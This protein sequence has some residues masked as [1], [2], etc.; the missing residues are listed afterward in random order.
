MK[1]Y[2]IV[3][4]VIFLISS[5]VSGQDNFHIDYDYSRLCLDEKSGYIEIYYSF[6]PLEM[7]K[8][9]VEEDTCVT[10]VI[11]IKIGKKRVRDLFVDRT[12][13]L[14]SKVG[15]QKGSHGSDLVGLFRFELPE[16]EYYCDITGYDGNDS[17]KQFIDSFNFE[18]KELKSD[19]FTVSDLQLA[20]SIKKVT[21]SDESPFYK[22]QYEVIPNPSLMFGSE[23][24]VVFLYCELYGINLSPESPTL[25]IEYRLVDSRNQELLKKTKFIPSSIPSMVFVKPINVHNYQ[26]GRHQMTLTVSDTIKKISE[27]VSK[28]FYIYNPHIVDTSEA[29]VNAVV[30]ASEYFSMSEKEIEDLFAI[31]RYIASNLEVQ[32][33][34]R[35]SNYHDKQVFLY[36]FWRARDP[37]PDSPIN[38]MKEEYLRRARVADERFGTLKTKGSATDRG[39]VYCLYGEPSDIERFP[40]DIEAKPYEIWHYDNIEGRVI[41]V[42]ADLYGFSS[43]Y[44]IHSTKQGELYDPDWRRKVNAF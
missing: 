33:W 18:I 37:S 44:L 7:K 35:L 23:L 6:R 20:S 41:F 15:K 43:M 40:S 12:W 29:S 34:N 27:Q 8:T 25:K 19:Q 4:S 36:H 9:V 13:E 26:S 32:E 30:V 42:F 2:T 39:R 21:E 28:S 16:G 3:I 31:S 1:F 17:L 11:S 14:S 24:P 38:E 22:N 10:G 5:F